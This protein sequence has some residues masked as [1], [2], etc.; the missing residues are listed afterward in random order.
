[1]NKISFDYFNKRNTLL[2]EAERGRPWLEMLA[3]PGKGKKVNEIFNKIGI[4]M[5]TG[6]RIPDPKDPSEM[7]NVPGLRDNTLAHRKLRYF[8]YMMTKQYENYTFSEDPTYDDDAEYDDE[9]EGLSP[10]DVIQSNKSANDT[11]QIALEILGLSDVPAKDRPKPLK[12][13]R[14]AII[15]FVQ[16]NDYPASPE[17]EK[18][19]LD[20]TTILNY[21]LYNRIIKTSTYS[22]DKARDI[23]YRYNMRLEDHN[24]IVSRIR[25]L[26]TLIRKA[27]GYDERTARKMASKAEQQSL[28]S[29][30]LTDN[31]TMILAVIDNMNYYYQYVQQAVKQEMAKSNIVDVEDV[32]IDLKREE[33]DL[34]L[35]LLNDLYYNTKVPK[36][37]TSLA[38]AYTKQKDVGLEP[39]S[40]IEQLETLKANNP[41]HVLDHIISEFKEM[42]YRDLLMRKSA[43][44]RYSNISTNYNEK[45]KP[46]EKYAFAFEPKYLI[47]V[48]ET[49]QDLKLFDDWFTKI[50]ENDLWYA[51]ETTDADLMEIDIGI[52]PEPN[53]VAKIDAALARLSSKNKKEQPTNQGTE[54]YPY[55][56]DLE[57]EYGS[58]NDDEDDDDDFY[59]ESYVMNYMTEQID[60]DKLIKPRGKY[61]DKG[62]KKVKNYNHWLRLNS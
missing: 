1:M 45:S 13:Y 23:E 33:L 53:E 57:D 55:S 35:P 22:I 37:L 28:I 47:D 30:I 44:E 27:K 12:L 19:A 32:L 11:Y 7:I 50:Y 2:T 51:K 48:I 31:V 49:E 52:L 8:I 58:Y 24:S 3:I 20:E 39:K 18:L 61:I 14:A 56:D 62:Y 59:K 17:F 38:T 25:P 36:L 46:F 21:A 4:V 41:K 42:L 15:K 5:K 16:D 60:K 10:E 9:N 29:N 26:L 40:I 43:K 6:G 34:S 54:E